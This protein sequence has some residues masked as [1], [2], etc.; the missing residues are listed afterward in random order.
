MNLFT[1]L[2][3]ATLVCLLE[4]TAFVPVAQAHNLSTTIQGAKW[5]DANGSKGTATI[6]SIDGKRM[7]TSLLFVNLKPIAISS[8]QHLFQIGSHFSDGSFF[9][10]WY[11]G[12]TTISAKLQA[13]HHY[14]VFGKATGKSTL[15]I[16]IKDEKGNIVAR[17][18]NSKTIRSE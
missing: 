16:L 7:N 14:T 12:Y 11:R 18:N 17:S 1:I 15:T 9:H 3:V 6:D 4:P 10:G 2:K 5:N 8:G 13:N